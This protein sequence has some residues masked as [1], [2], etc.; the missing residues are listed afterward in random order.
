[1]F[2][3]FVIIICGET[4]HS[5]NL[6][7]GNGHELVVWQKICFQIAGTPAARALGDADAPLGA[8]VC[9]RQEERPP[10]AQLPPSGGGDALYICG[11]QSPHLWLCRAATPLCRVA[12]PCLYL[13][14][15]V[16]C[17]VKNT[18]ETHLNASSE[19]SVLNLF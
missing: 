2:L 8:E 12:L 9:D 5:R 11:R 6:W 15:E 7:R 1:M 3:R 14:P 4:K 10:R 18:K 19:P 16:A 17:L 13:L